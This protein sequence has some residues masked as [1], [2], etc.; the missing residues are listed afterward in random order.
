MNPSG[1]ETVDPTDPASPYYDDQLC[2]DF[3]SG[4]SARD[5]KCTV[6]PATV[7]WKM[8]L[9]YAAPAGT[10]LGYKWVRINMKTNRVAAPYFVDQKGDPT[11]LDTRVCW[12]GQ[13][14]QLSPGGVSPACDAN[15]MQPVYMLTSLAMAEGTRNLLRA[16]VVS[17]SIRPPGAIT[18][19]VG[20][21]TSANP[22]P[23]TFN[24]PAATNTALIPST[25]IDGRP[26]DVNGLPPTITCDSLLCRRP[27]VCVMLT[28]PPLHPTH[29]AHARLR[30]P[31]CGEQARLLDSPQPSF[32]PRLPLRPCRF[33][34]PRQ[35]HFTAAAIVDTVVAT[36][37][38]RPRRQRLHRYPRQRR[39]LRSTTEAWI[40]RRHSSVL[41]LCLW[42]IRGTQVIRR[43]INPKHRTLWRMRTRRFST[44]LL[45]ARRLT[46]ITMSL[47]LQA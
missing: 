47:R 38:I 26:H 24:V 32:Q 37:M 45:P 4:V 11:T 28:D 2:H 25:S 29:P 40:S 22:I 20:T 34:S 30:W 3:N 10:P 27:I 33:L 13:T 7:N 36:M 46:R 42:A 23:A 43:P 39:S 14:E 41:Y 5:S 6:I 35:R 44:I 15:G 31:G 17:S 1:G 9:Q 8:P 12:D 21:S 18:M 19:D 16:E